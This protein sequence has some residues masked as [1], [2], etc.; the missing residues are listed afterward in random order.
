ME[1]DGGM[2]SKQ[3][4]GYPIGA[5]IIIIVLVAILFMIGNLTCER[6]DAGEN[7]FVLLGAI[8]TVGI[9][10]VLV[11]IVKALMKGDDSEE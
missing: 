8:A 6:W 9:F 5:T 3:N 11:V 1:G 10:V 7:E 2:S 4:K